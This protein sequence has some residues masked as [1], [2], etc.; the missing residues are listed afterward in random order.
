MESKYQSCDSA[1]DP[2][3]SG[4]LVTSGALNA[5]EVH[6]LAS[7]LSAVS[8]P[9]RLMMLNMI[10]Q[11]GGDLCVCEFERVFSLSQPTI[12]HHLK[13]LR[14]AGF[15]RSE[16]VGHWVHHYI[17]PETFNR[18]KRLFGD[19]GQVSVPGGQDNESS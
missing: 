17:V 9:L 2:C 12:S 8:N 19:F 14:D 6:V 7:R 4:P 5:A 15:V 13:L 16:R 1:R 3:E 11:R 10:H 18:I